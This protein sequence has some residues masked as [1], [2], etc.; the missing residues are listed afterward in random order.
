PNPLPVNGEGTSNAAIVGA[1]VPLANCQITTTHQVRLRETPS[2][3]GTVLT[4][5][6]YDLT[7]TATVRTGDWYQV[8]YLNNQGWVN[9][10]YVN[11]RGTCG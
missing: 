2:T 5:L 4:T 7:L 9:A 6:P 1:A 10:A 11:T 8:V 3:N